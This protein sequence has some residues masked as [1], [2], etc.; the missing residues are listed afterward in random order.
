MRRHQLDL[1]R[2][3][4]DKIP[5]GYLE[6]YDRV[7]EPWIGRKIVLLELGVRTGGSLSLWRD[8]FPDGSIVGVD[9]RL[10]TGLAPDDRIHV[11]QGNQGD[12]TFLSTVAREVAPGGFD[13]IID[14]ASHIGHL[15]K[16]SFWHLF[17]NHLRP[18]G[19]YAIEDWGTGYYDDWP[20][21]KRYTE[22][23]PSRAGLWTYFRTRVHAPPKI[24]SISHS[25]GM[26]GF[27][28]QLVDEQGAADL[29]RGARAGRPSRASRFE[30]LLI[31]A[32]IV[33]VTKRS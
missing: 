33:F 13:I 6:Y 31:T 29:T 17:E 14:D 4:T 7:L 9:L 26:V 18:G 22:P 8:Y 24:P 21:G 16:L 23:V 30:S 2:Y 28:K 25:Y 32:P 11:F 5:N 15:T 19:L 3:D 27:V 1:S 12:S 20:D 10:P